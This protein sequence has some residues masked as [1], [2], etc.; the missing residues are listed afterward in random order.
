[1]NN[2]PE[3]QPS[4]NL[5]NPPSAIDRKAYAR[6]DAL[7]RE[8]AIQQ[9]R[10]LEMKAREEQLTKEVAIAKGNLELKD[11]MDKALVELQNVAHE[12]SVGAFE[13]MLSAIVQD[14]DPQ[15]NTKIS[16]NL[17]MKSGL[18]HLDIA[19]SVHGKAEAITSGA[20]N[21]IL[22]TGL[23]FITLARSGRQRFMLLDEPD[24]YMNEQSAQ[25]F[26]SVVEQLATDA[27]IQ[28]LLITH[29]DLEKFQNTFRVYR[30]SEVESKDKWPRRTMDLVSEGEMR[31]TD[32]QDRYLNFIEAQNFESFSHS[33][34]KLSPGV[35]A[36]TGINGRGK[37]SWAR[38]L[39]SAFMTDT[40]DEVIRHD[41]TEA[42]VSI[43]FS[44]GPV[45]QQIRRTKGKLKGEFILHTADSYDYTMANPEWRKEEFAPKPLHY[46]TGLTL[47]DWVGLETRMDPI[48]KM[49]VALR[50]QLLPTFMLDRP[51]SEKA[52]LLSIGRESGHLFE[53]VQLYKSDVLADRRK[54]N[55]GE[56]EIAMLRKT[57]EALA[58]VEY[59]LNA[60][61]ILRSQLGDILDEQEKLQLETNLLLELS[62]VSKELDENLAIVEKCSAVS[63]PP[64]VE[65]TE[66]FPI[67]FDRL[68][69]AEQDINSQLNFSPIETPEVIETYGLENWVNQ[70]ETELTVEHEARN[71][72]SP[73]ENINILETTIQFEIIDKLHIATVDSEITH[74]ERIE[75]PEIEETSNIN[76]VIN[77]L[78]RLDIEI[79]SP[80]LE[81]INSPEI[82]ETKAISEFMI[83]LNQSEIDSSI[84]FSN[85]VLN[86]GIE[87]TDELAQLMHEIEMADKLMAGAQ[88]SITSLNETQK[89]LEQQLDAAIEVLGENWQMDPQR[90][91]NIAN[92]IIQSTSANGEKATCMIT[93]LHEK[94]GLAAKEGYVYGLNENADKKINKRYES[95]NSSLPRPK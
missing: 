55:D 26:F 50:D 34:I 21:N 18:P 93:V 88:A 41:Q 47:P 33:S 35:T 45:Y 61:R 53:M 13:R 32:L 84:P 25:N 37:S 12:R 65:V 5:D 74:L 43:G 72:P 4:S 80:I 44:D 60:E 63:E 92:S 22:S 95:Q 1:M 3:N 16:L 10:L 91:E 17:G 6:L 39:R 81:Q 94:L 11:E 69:K 19:A 8:S 90:V 2:L 59:L 58:P 23:R 49:N 27:G 75:N 71:I 28:V 20:L 56:V 54:S 66:G 70:Y 40:G 78:R 79:S 86:P 42:S 83:Q 30:V 64:K 48:E 51:G 67:W 9:G 31:P 87:S 15:S 85:G 89:I 57:I 46:S 82:Q 29:H 68:S 76:D 73:I 62:Q 38:M 52:S 36:I 24:C 77:N 7:A 14:V